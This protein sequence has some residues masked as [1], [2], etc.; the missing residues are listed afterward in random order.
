MNYMTYIRIAHYS[1]LSKTAVY[2]DFRFLQPSG[3]TLV[4]IYE[5]GHVPFLR[6]I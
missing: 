4:Y 3:R 2:P 1:N 6:P 5:I